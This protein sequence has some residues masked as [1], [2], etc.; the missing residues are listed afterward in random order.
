MGTKDP[1][2]QSF[3]AGDFRGKRSSRG[4]DPSEPPSADELTHYP[5]LE[6]ILE[7]EEEENFQKTCQNTCRNLDTLVSHQSKPETTV[8]CQSALA[9][10]GHSLKLLAELINIKYE[11]LQQQAEQE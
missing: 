5:Y 1:N 2:L 4:S 10:Y 3:R 7:S 11:K 6:K 8:M 9:A